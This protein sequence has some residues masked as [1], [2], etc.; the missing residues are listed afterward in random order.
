[1]LLS[2]VRRP[3]S[4]AVAV[5][6][7]LR[8]MGESEGR[9][10]ASAANPHRRAMAVVLDDQWRRWQALKATGQDGAAADLPRPGWVLH[11]GGSGLE[12]LPQSAGESAGAYRWVGVVPDSALTRQLLAELDALAAPRTKDVLRLLDHLALEM[13]CHLTE[14]PAIPADLF[15]CSADTNQ[16]DAPAQCSASVPCG[17]AG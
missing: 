10:L 6:L 16:T 15:E 7:V 8:A 5:R 13:Q 4:G 14:L 3:L 11:A 12:R 17:C 9:Q 2:L 1:M